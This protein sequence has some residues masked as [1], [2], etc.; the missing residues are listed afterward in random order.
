[1]ML[2]SFVFRHRQISPFGLWPHSIAPLII[3]R[4]T[5]Q[6][7]SIGFPLPEFN[8]VSRAYPIVIYFRQNARQRYDNTF[9]SKSMNVNRFNILPFN[10]VEKYTKLIMNKDMNVFGIPIQ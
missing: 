2:F 9:A 10:V 8:N 3:M 6:S 4:T 5:F 7:D 1:M